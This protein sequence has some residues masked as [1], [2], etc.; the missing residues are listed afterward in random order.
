MNSGFSLISQIRLFSELQKFC[1]NYEHGIRLAKTKDRLYQDANEQ[2]HYN[3]P[4]STFI[5]AFFV[6]N[7]IYNIDWYTSLQ[8]PSHDVK[9]YEKVR[10]K[11]S[12][13]EKFWNLVMISYQ[14]NPIITGDYAQ[15]LR[16]Y[17]KV[18]GVNNPVRKIGDISSR[19]NQD[20][21]KRLADQYKTRLSKGSELTM[22]SIADFIKSFQTLYQY[23]SESASETPETYQKHLNN[24]LYFVYLVRNNVF[25]GKKGIA[26][27]HIGPSQEKRLLVYAAVLLAVNQ[28]ILDYC[29]NTL[30]I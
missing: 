11:P 18:F 3:R 6:F 17:C 27:A 26:V 12:E 21:E 4:A 23:N 20:L 25:H 30:K 14:S 24:I 2:S 5:Y 16:A 1:L 13:Q 7:S 9:D 10:P 15:Y 29:R 22:M 28:L 19:N 8:K